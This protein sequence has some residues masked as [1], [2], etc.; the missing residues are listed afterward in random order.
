MP[1]EKLFIPF[2]DKNRILVFQLNYKIL[3][4]IVSIFDLNKN[5]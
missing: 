1:A 5:S 4:G 2:Y 3:K